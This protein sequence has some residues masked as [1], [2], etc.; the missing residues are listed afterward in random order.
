MPLVSI[1]LLEIVPFLLL[2][3]AG[4]RSRGPADPGHAREMAMAAG[5][6]VQ[7]GWFAAGGHI[8]CSRREAVVRSILTRAPHT[9]SEAVCGPR[10]VRPGLKTFLHFA[11]NTFAE[12]AE[13]PMLL[14]MRRFLRMASR[15][16]RRQE[17]L[18]CLAD[19]L[20][21]ATRLERED[22][23]GRLAALMTDLAAALGEREAA[24]GD[25]AIAWLYGLRAAWL[26]Q[27][28]GGRGIPTAYAPP[29]LCRAA[30][31]LLKES[32]RG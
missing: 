28:L 10:S 31:Q 17:L 20:R 32:A 14:E 25:R 30:S 16:R 2:A 4:S 22:A 13:M 27:S 19:G 26:W 11:H 15:L 23:V 9:V 12:P 18:E 24:A 7:A 6:L 5:A 29:H 3:G 21:Q 8:P 1:L